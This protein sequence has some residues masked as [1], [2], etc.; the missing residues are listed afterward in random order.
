MDLLAIV[1]LSDGMRGVV[2]VDV[3]LEDRFVVRNVFLLNRCD[4]GGCDEG[5]LWCCVRMYR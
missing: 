2:R 4:G 1:V 3:G 5:D